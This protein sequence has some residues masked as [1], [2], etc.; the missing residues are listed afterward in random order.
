MSIIVSMAGIK[1][2]AKGKRD[3]REKK[4]RSTYRNVGKKGEKKKSID[5]I[6]MEMFRQWVRPRV[7]ETPRVK[8]KQ[9]AK[10]MGWGWD[11]DWGWGWGW[12]WEQ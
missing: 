4:I 7:E 6:E 1:E 10:K 3:G 8:V 2:S 12:G 5:T 11:W 9:R